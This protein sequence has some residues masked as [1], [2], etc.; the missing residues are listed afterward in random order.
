MGTKETGGSTIKPASTPATVLEASESRKTSLE[1]FMNA[2]QGVKRSLYLAVR[3]KACQ[4]ARNQDAPVTRLEWNAISIEDQTAAV[5]ARDCIRQP[6]R[7]AHVLKKMVA[8][9]VNPRYS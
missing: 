6:G 3:V 7:L 8:S 9:S 2:S 1:I 5:G 4:S